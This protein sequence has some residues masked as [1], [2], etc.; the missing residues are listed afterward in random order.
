MVKKN[1]SRSRNTGIGAR[2]G[3]I[4]S[5]PAVVS[6]QAAKDGNRKLVPVR[7]PTGLPSHLTATH[8]QVIL[9]IGGSEGFLI[10]G[11]NVK[12]TYSTGWVEAEKW[13][14][15]YV[16]ASSDDLVISMQGGIKWRA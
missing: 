9:T 3:T 8:Y 2:N 1:K 15:F 10:H 16:D 6:P 12:K 13:K 5:A 4:P 11:G 7:A 14:D